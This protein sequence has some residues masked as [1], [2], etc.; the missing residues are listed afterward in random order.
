MIKRKVQ[1]KKRYIVAFLIGTFLFL[2]IVVGGYFFA[3]IQYNRISNLQG[4]TFYSIYEGKSSYTLFGEDIC[5]ENNFREISD[6][7]VFQGRS[8][9]DLEE[10]LG[11][12]DKYV[13]EQKKFYTVLLLEHLDYVNLYNERCSEDILYLLFFYS[14]LGEKEELSSNAGKVLDQV[15]FNN[16]NLVIYSF[17]CDLE[18][19]IIN[20]LKN[21]YNIT[22]IPSVIVDGNT[23]LNWPFDVSDV[24][25][26]LS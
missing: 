8:I 14:N 10:K 5:L 26:Y 7:L 20:S 12:T 18:S 22:Y 4:I 19:S 1:S 2:L 21:K 3:Q 11:K 23:V 16:K 9:D 13:L 24:E 6:L 15:Y 17:D 25:K